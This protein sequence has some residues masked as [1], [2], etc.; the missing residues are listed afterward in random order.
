MMDLEIL[1]LSSRDEGAAL[2]TGP[3]ST[4]KGQ[5]EDESSNPRFNAALGALSER[6]TSSIGRSVFARDNEMC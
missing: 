5:S 1:K 4:L 3:Y 6:I 2:E